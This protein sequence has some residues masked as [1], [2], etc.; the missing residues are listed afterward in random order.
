[1]SNDA[2]GFRLISTSVLAYRIVVPSSAILFVGD[3]LKLVDHDKDF[4]FFAKV[5]DITHDTAQGE[6]AAG[7]TLAV[8]LHPLGLIDHDGRFRPPM[9][10]PTNFAE[11]SRPDDADLEFLKQSMGDLEVGQMRAGLG[12][13]EGVTVSLPS[14]TLSSHMGVF[15]T[16]GM[17][18][19]NFMKVLCASAMRL[20]RF[21]VLMVDPHGEYVTGYRLR[22]QRIKGLIEYT[23]ARDGLS[24]YSTRPPDERKRYGLKELRLE[25]DDFRMGDLGFLYEL[26]LPLIEVVESLDSHAGSD[27]IDFFI[28]E[29]VDSLPSPLKTTSGIGRHPE[30]TD[31][32]R[33][34]AL[35]PLHMTQRRV[36]TVVEENRVFFH[37]FGS[38]I[39]SILEDLA[40]NKV[41]LIDIPGVS[42][43]GELFALSTMTRAILN[44]HKLR[45]LS[46]EETSHQQV[47]IAIEEAQRVLAEANQSTQVFRECVMEGRKFGVGLCLVTQQP[48]NIDPRILAQLNTYVVMGLADQQDRSIVAGNAKQ[49]LASMNNEIQTLPRGDAVISIMGTPFPVSTRIHLFEDYL[50]R[51]DAAS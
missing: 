24:V 8:N 6:P 45:T 36:E 42:E 39:P 9:T 49:N 47:L 12:I 17:G 38:S 37:R 33:T 14:E 26:S 21:G 29:G 30:I 3:I 31:T 22:N 50:D 7:P 51:L 48:K 4:T 2:A 10:A 11:V 23:G 44:A 41:V 18:K 34:Y 40:Q 15:A 27:V 1:M 28:N 19:S 32:L 25:H 46:D 43:R 35:G 16:T 13:L 5:T 20:R